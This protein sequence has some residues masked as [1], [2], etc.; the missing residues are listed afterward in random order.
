MK[1]KFTSRLLMACMVLFGWALINDESVFGQD[2]KPQ[3]VFISSPV[4][5]KDLKRV[6]VLPLTCKKSGADLLD[7]CEM[8]NPVLQA[9]LV[10]TKKFE[11]IPVGSEM[12]RSLTGKFGWTG[13]EVLPP[14]F[15]NSLEESY[16]C[17]AVLFCQLTVFR[18]YAPLAVGW[19]MKL[20]DVHSQ[21]IIWAADE[22]FDANEPAVARGAEQFE[23]HQQRIH[24]E[25]A[26]L[27]KAFWK[28][29]DREPQPVLDDQWAILN[30]PRYFGQYSAVKLLESLPER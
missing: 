3:N 15:F 13:A 25:T 1:K 12:L 23:K 22:V 5:P 21:K 9:Q 8:L 16:G 30:S 4:L 19:R 18:A 29:A 26:F 27:F 6:V 24:G 7:G 28:L 14:D 20:V 11:V 2:A 10:K 17:D